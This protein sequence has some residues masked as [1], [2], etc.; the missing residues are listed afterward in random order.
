MYFQRSQVVQ[1]RKVPR[2]IMS[3]DWR[4]FAGFPEWS[5]DGDIT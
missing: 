5:Y 3:P 1:E 4:F 2:K